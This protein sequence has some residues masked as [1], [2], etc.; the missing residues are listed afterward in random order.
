MLRRDLTRLEVGSVDFYQEFVHVRSQ[1]LKRQQ[2]KEEEAR[3]A[4]AQDIST[5]TPGGPRGAR[6]AAMSAGQPAG[7]PPMRLSQGGPGGASAARSLMA[8]LDDSELPTAHGPPSM[9]APGTAALAAAGMPAAYAAGFA[10][11]TAAP[12]MQQW[13][14][15]PHPAGPP[16]PGPAGGPA[17]WGGMRHDGGHGP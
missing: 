16:P 3:R 15:P 8:A 14:P 1:E 10:A 2:Q 5:E 6:G 9:A 7:Q 12:G 11:G 4:A 13:A 17:G